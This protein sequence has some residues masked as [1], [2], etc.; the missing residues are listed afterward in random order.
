ME[1]TVDFDEWVKTFVPAEPEYYAIYDK[2]SGAVT[3]IYPDHSSTNFENRLKIDR[4]LAESI[5]SGK[6]NM[7]NCFVDFNSD[8]LE[9]VQVHSLRKIDDILHRIIDKA[10]SDVSKSDVIVS[11]IV[12]EKKIKFGLTEFFT[13]RKIRWSGDTALRFLICSYNDPH[14]IYQIINLTLDELNSGEKEYKLETDDEKFSVFTTR[15]LKTYT[16]ERI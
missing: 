7:S 4:E 10:Y 6:L 13:K 15:V 3:G 8:V 9:I 1:E 2:E 5:F 11:H 14:K 16:L 12:K